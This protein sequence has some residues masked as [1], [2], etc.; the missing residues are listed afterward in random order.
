MPAIGV[1]PPPR[2]LVIV[3]AMVPVDEPYAVRDWFG[4]ADPNGFC[5]RPSNVRF[6]TPARVAE[7]V[8]VAIPGT[9]LE[10]W[11]PGKVPN[12]RYDSAGCGS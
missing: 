2:T 10:G 4:Y 6:H 12:S 1:R 8:L 9:Q 7:W 5:G 3:R 11:V